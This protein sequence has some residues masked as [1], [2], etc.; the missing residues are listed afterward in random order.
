LGLTISGVNHFTIP[1]R[2]HGKARKFW[3]ELLG[4][5]VRRE[6]DWESVRQGRSNS[7]AMA[8][9]MCEGMELDLFYQPYGQGTLD[10][11]FPHNAFWVQAPEE[12]DAFRDRL[13]AS[14][15]PTVLTTP[16]TDNA[17]KVGE[18]VL[19]EMHFRDPDGNPTE[20]ACR[21]YPFNEQVKIGSFD[22]W[23]TA[24]LWR[25]WPRA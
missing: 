13:E 11:A 9:R 12:L 25:D 5:E 17:P 15:T 1:V 23:D 6:P 2:D 10:Q 19:V 22:Q 24:Y 16:A 21:N 7:T 4:G 20:I 3:V 14:G 8:V 18:A